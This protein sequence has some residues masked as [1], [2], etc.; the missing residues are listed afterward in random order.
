MPSAERHTSHR[1]EEEGGVMATSRLNSPGRR[2]GRRASNPEMGSGVPRRSGRGRRPSGPTEQNRASHNGSLSQEARLA[3]G[4]GWFGIGL[5]LAELLVPRRFA[6]T[7]GVPY[8]HHRL[9][10]VMGVREIANG[11]GILIWPSASAGRVGTR[12][13][14][15]RR[16]GLS[17]SRVHICQR[18]P[19]PV[20]YR[21]GGRR[22]GGCGRPP[23][24][25]TADTRHDDAGRLH[26]GR[27][28][29]EDQSLA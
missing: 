18:K 24:R 1:A 16:S 7:I 11:L 29:A 19:K 10:R 6:R 27:R 5:G 4:L 17:W 21:C 8:E 20:G 2:K 26:A 14:R 12:G 28:A 22:R 3:F 15:H 9:I 13:R 23:L 25:A